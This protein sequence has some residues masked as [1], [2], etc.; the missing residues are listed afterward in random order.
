MLQMIGDHKGG[1]PKVF[2]DCRIQHFFNL[3]G[4]MSWGAYFIDRVRI[5]ERR[6]APTCRMRQVLSVSAACIAMRK[7]PLLGAVGTLARIYD[8]YTRAYLSGVTF[9]KLG[10]D[11]L[12]ARGGE[13]KGSPCN[14]ANLVQAPTLADGCRQPCCRLPTR[15]PARGALPCCRSTLSALR[16][17]RLVAVVTGLLGFMS[18]ERP[19]GWYKLPKYTAERSLAGNEGTFPCVRRSNRE[20]DAEL[21]VFKRTQQRILFSRSLLHTLVETPEV[22]ELDLVRRQKDPAAWLAKQLQVTFPDDAEIIR[23]S[24]MGR[25]PDALYILVDRLVALYLR[26]VNDL[27]RTYREQRLRSLDSVYQKKQEGLRGEAR[28]VDAARHSTSTDPRGVFSP[29]QQLA[30]VQFMDTHREWLRQQLALRAPRKRHL[31]APCRTG[32]SRVPRDFTS[33]LGGGDAVRSDGQRTAGEA[34]SLAVRA[35]SNAI[36][37]DRVRGRSITGPPESGNAALPA[38]A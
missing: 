25:D 33:G 35:V 13:R 31:H 32:T 3:C 21:V 24:S 16:R 22:A 11:G 27:R 19:F 38:P 14:R 5:R 37:C 6:R 23:V 1:T 7:Y 20:P 28:F 29:E 17:H 8:L 15:G 2:P 26:E 4:T 18:A 36:A 34:W 30:L 10:N 12:A 9:P